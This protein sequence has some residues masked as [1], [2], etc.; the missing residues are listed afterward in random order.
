MDDNAVIY[1][2]HVRTITPELAERPSGLA[3]RMAL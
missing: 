1:V 2:V 3:A